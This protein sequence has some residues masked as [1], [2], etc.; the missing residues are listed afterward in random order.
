M[1]PKPKLKITR[2]KTGKSSEIFKKEYEN[3]KFRKLYTM[4]DH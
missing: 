3:L 2:L 4:F 1:P